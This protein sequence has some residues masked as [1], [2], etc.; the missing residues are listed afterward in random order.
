MATARASSRLF[1]RAGV[2]D[3]SD[4]AKVG[5]YS[6]GKVGQESCGLAKSCATNTERAK[7]AANGLWLAVM[8][9]LLLEIIFS[10]N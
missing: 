1:A 3:A 8:E 7:Q 9:I 2:R 6:L 5:R 4:A 10:T